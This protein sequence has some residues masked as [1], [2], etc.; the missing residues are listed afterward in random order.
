MDE[1]AKCEDELALALEE[2]AEYRRSDEG[3]VTT[4]QTSEHDRRFVD[5]K[6]ILNVDEYRFKKEELLREKVSRAEQQLAAAQR[7]WL[8]FVLP[9]DT[10]G[11]PV[12]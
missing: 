12:M 7:R 9:P 3:Y 1:I 6:T 5:G 10:F 11:K 8:R 2:L 4:R